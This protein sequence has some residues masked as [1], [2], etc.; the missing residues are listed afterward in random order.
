[1]SSTI[2][3]ILILTGIMFL[4]LI[5]TFIPD[6]ESIQKEFISDKDAKNIAK[7]EFDK[8]VQENDPMIEPWKQSILGEP[9]MVKTLE[10]KPSYWTVPVI[11]KDKVI[12]F[13]DVGRDKTVSRY[14]QFYETPDNLSSCPYVITFTTPEEAKELTKEIISKYSDAKISEPIFV[15]DGA[16]SKTAWM[17]KVEK[18]DKITN[19]IFVSGRYV[20]E[21]KEGESDSGVLT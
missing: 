4:L 1:M 13:I 15:H 7:Y 12:G 10:E 5:Y 20:Y 6:K 2:K 19:R 14:G 16:E 3:Y 18:G 21:R 17:L 11:L 9:V 8:I